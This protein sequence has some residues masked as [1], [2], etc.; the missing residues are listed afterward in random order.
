MILFIFEDIAN[1]IEA[2]KNF[3]ASIYD[4][5]MIAFSFLPEPLDKIA[6]SFVVIFIAVLIVKIIRG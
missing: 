6:I 3:F 5:I 1:Y 2:I 4:L